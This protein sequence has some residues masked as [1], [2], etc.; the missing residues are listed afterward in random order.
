V[1]VKANNQLIS[2]KANKDYRVKIGE[3][4]N[5]S[6]PIKKCHLFDINTGNILNKKVG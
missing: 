2:I 4:I 5:V 6:V 1:T 3:T